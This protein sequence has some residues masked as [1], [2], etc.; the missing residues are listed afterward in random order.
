MRDC[1]P[2]FMH[3]HYYHHEPFFILFHFNEQGLLTETKVHTSL[4]SKDLTALP[5]TSPYFSIAQKCFLNCLSE[6]EV[7]FILE[8]GS[9]S[10]FES[11]VLK[12]LCSI[13]PGNTITYKGLSEHIKRPNASRA[14]GNVMRKNPFPILFPCHRVVPSHGHHVGQYSSGGPSMKVLLLEHERKISS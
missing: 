1:Y 10:P 4:P 6:K 3:T 7:T 9:F 12:G 5:K 14:V 2:E 13:P 11:L 8:Q